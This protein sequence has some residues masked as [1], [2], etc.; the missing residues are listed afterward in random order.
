VDEALAAGLSDAG[1]PDIESF[2]KNDSPN[3]TVA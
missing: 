2:F 3:Q 1:V